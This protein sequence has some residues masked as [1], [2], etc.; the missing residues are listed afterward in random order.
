MFNKIGFYV[1]FI[2]ILP[3]CANY[4]VKKFTFTDVRIQGNDDEYMNVKL[5]SNNFRIFFGKKI[6]LP[7]TTDK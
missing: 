3:S 5:R 4:E 6:K 2:L 1:L 7:L